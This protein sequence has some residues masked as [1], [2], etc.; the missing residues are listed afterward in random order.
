MA[1]DML[2]GGFRWSLG[3]GEGMGKGWPMFGMR[4]GCRKLGAD[5]Q[6]GG[7]REKPVAMAGALSVCARVDIAFPSLLLL[8]SEP[9]SCG[10][11]QSPHAHLAAGVL[12]S[13]P[14]PYS[15]PSPPLVDAEGGPGQ[16]S[17]IGGRR[18]FQLQVLPWLCRSQ[19]LQGEKPL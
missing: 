2:E 15:P 10:L 18:R 11:H 5:T 17:R 4:E 13:D 12:A 14:E 6:V 7:R 19:R 16:H 8:Q 3:G 1:V 9:P